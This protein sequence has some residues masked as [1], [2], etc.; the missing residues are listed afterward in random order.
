[1]WRFQPSTWCGSHG[2]PSPAAV[3]IAR[4]ARLARL[5]RPA[6]HEKN[7]DVAGNAGKSVQHSVRISRI[8]SINNLLQLLALLAMDLELRTDPMR[9][10]AMRM[11]EILAQHLVQ[12]SDILRMLLFT[13]FFFIIVVLRVH[14]MGTGL[15][16]PHLLLL[17]TM[18]RLLLTT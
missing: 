8:F 15:E 4:L 12:F 6:G 3:V 9:N 13:Q 10:L 2:V 18:T 17:A 1:M 7:N 11:T 14:Q 5:A 16:W